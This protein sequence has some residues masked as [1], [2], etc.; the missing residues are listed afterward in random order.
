MSW[1]M[2]NINNVK[3]DVIDDVSLPCNNSIEIDIFFLRCCTV[4]NTYSYGIA[5]LVIYV[6][7]NSDEFPSLELFCGAKKLS[8]VIWVFDYLLAIME[9][10][11]SLKAGIY[12]PPLLAL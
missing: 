4:K 11:K 2:A 1:F 9:K 7:L 12:L 8:R 5:K 10:K 3:Q 6:M